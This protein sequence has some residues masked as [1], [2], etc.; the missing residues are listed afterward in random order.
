MVKSKVFPSAILEDPAYINYKGVWD[1]QDLYESMIDFFMRRKYKFQEKIYKHKHPSPFGVER[2]YIWEFWRKE[3]DYI[4]IRY[5]VYIHVYDLHDIEVV[6]PDGEK[7]TYAK[8]RMYME[9]KAFTESDYEGRWDENKFYKN[10]KQF[11]NAYIIRKNYTQ[12]WN[13]KRRY[14]MYEFVSMV[15]HK[16]K[17]EADEYEHRHFAGVHKKY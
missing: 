7:K 16:L 10:L 14:E 3:N 17:M 11:Y 12:G 1:M 8:G 15:K 5:Q 2:Q 13:P 4:L 9:V 6:T